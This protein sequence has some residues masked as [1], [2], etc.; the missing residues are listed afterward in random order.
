MLPSEGS[1]TIS[2]LNKV[3]ND[4]AECTKRMILP[5]CGSRRMGEW[6]LRRV[7]VTVRGCVPSHSEHANDGCDSA[8]VQLA[9]PFQG[10]T[11]DCAYHN[12]EIKAV[13]RL[14]TTGEGAGMSV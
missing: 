2:V 11:D 5:D 3:R 4:L 7:L 13:P 6:S 14:W 8:N 9:T 1:V 12:G 10:Q